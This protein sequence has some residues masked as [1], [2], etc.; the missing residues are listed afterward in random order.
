LLHTPVLIQS[1]PLTFPLTSKSNAPL[2]EKHI[3][4]QEHC[5]RL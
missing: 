1:T 4:Y 3:F 2:F 5:I